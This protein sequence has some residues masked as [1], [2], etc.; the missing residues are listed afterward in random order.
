MWIAA[1]SGMRLN[2]ICSLKVSDVK[3]EEGVWFFDVT[4]AKTEAGDRRVPVRRTLIKLGLLK[5]AKGITGEWLYPSLIPGGSDKKRGWYMSR[6][7]GAY[8]R[9]LKVVRLDDADAAAPTST[10]S[11]DPRSV[12]WRRPACPSRKP[13]RW[14]DTSAV[15]SRSGP[16]TPKGWT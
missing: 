13:P 16:T 2:E 1:F 6:A 4:G 14:S 15:A 8:R 10:A 11:G 9:R 3:R 5:Y 12:A 7:L